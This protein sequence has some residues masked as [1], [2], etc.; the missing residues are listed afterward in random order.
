MNKI[1]TLYQLSLAD[2]RER[3]RRYSFLIT[4]LGVLFF[5]YLVITGKYSV[6]FG[7]CRT[8]YD[9]VWA[10]S[11]MAVCSS[12]MIILIGFYLVKGSISRD[13]KTEVG[14]IIASTQISGITYIISK[15]ISNLLILLLMTAVLAIVAFITL[16]YRN[17][18]GFID[19]WGFV[20]PFIF[21]S[22][23]ATMFT[24]AAAVFF[25]T[26]KWLRGSVGNIIYLFV[27]EFSIVFGMLEIPFMDLA[28]FSIFSD[29]VRTAIEAIFPGE[30]VGMVMGFIA[31][32]KTLQVD[33][34]R[35]FDWNG[36]VWTNAALMLRLFWIGVAGVVTGL[37][38]PFFDRFDPALIKHKLSR[39]ANKKKAVTESIEQSTALTNLPYKSLS[40]PVLR[41]SLTNMIVA[42]LRL[43]LKGYHWFWY[44][45]ALGLFFAQVFTPFE[46]ARQFIV[47]GAMIWPLIIWSSMGTRELHFNTSQLLFSSPEPVARQFPAVW[48]SGLLIAIGSVSPMILRALGTG[49]GM[50]ALALIIGVIFVPSLALMFGTL[51]RSKKMFEVVYLMLWYIGSVD[52]LAAI[53]VLGTL[54]ASVT[55]TKLIVLSILTI[56]FIIAAFQ[57]RRIQVNRS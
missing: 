47:P 44:A 24:A 22:I 41:F 8:V 36:I 43:A 2:I 19:L 16:L 17:E 31:L 37:A 49:E 34:Y 40:L 28:G 18:S 10:G 5:G 3:T 9:S 13:R 30:K 26:V 48:L 23:P 55:P 15:F 51:T 39:K 54:E 11:L 32:D 25:D 56:V 35:I 53:D 45:I 12:V 46:I 33:E 7:D 42:E 29:S 50:Y 14:Q 27:A 4:M 1:S 52:K 6:Q 57:T 38:I 21:I 20:S